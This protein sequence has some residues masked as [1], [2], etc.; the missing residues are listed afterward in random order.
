MMKLGLCCGGGLCCALLSAILWLGGGSAVLGQAP[1]VQAQKSVGCSKAGCTKAGCEK[2]R[3]AGAPCGMPTAN[4]ADVD[5]TP[6]EQKVVTYLADMIEGGR[7]PMLTGSELEKELGRLYKE[8]ADLRAASRA[9][10]TAGSS[11]PTRTERMTTTTNNST[12]VNAWFFSL[13]LMKY[14]VPMIKKRWR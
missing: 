9:D 7:A 1:D 5:L 11:K 2:H 3:T 4:T 12:R 8:N 14:S 13:I 6:D 10:C